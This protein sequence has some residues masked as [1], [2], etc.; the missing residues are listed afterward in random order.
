MTARILACALLLL[1]A[2]GCKQKPPPDEP[3]HTPPRTDFAPAE[4]G[5]G[6]A[7]T[8]DAACNRE[9]DQL[10][11]Q[12]RRCYNSRPTAECEVLQRGNSDQITRLKNSA[13][14]SR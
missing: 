9:I 10:L 1:T 3:S 2:A 4:F 5:I 8:M 6:R 12:V 7:H 13:R 11:D 14:C